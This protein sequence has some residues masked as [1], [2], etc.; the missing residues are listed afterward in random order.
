MKVSVIIPV[1]NAEKYIEATINSVLQQTYP[2]ELI[3]IVIVND[4]STDN[5]SEILKRYEKQYKIIHTE[6][7]GVSYARNI[8]LKNATGYFIQYLDSDDLLEYNKIEI[9]VSAL[10][11]NE[12]DVAYGN[13]QKFIEIDNSISISKTIERQ[14]EGD[15]EI[16][17][18]T[19]FWCPPAAILYSRKI[20]EK[21][22]PWKQ[23]LPIIQDAR[24][25]LDAALHKAK[26][27]YTD[28]NVALYR[29]DNP[30]SLSKREREF[31]IDCLKNCVDILSI[32]RIKYGEKSP[33]ANA[34]CLCLLNVTT[35]FRNSSSLYYGY[36]LKKLLKIN[37]N[38]VPAHKGFL[39]QMSLCFGYK[40]AEFFARVKQSFL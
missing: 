17:L 38:F 35:K 1:Y 26:F 18:F 9:Q 32:W 11:E 14:I 3:E 31:A 16:A 4:G 21:I 7:R 24:Y 27:V 6:N 23:W 34:I 2:K 29:E 20:V 28:E 12:A 25:F 22:G 30:N 19:Y 13:W 40:T 37:P 8:G 15:E 33:R 10:I 39:R 5:T 36:S